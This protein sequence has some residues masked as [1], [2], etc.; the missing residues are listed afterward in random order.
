MVDNR[1]THPLRE[2]IDQEKERLCLDFI[3][4]PG[5]LD[6]RERYVMTSYYLAEI[7]MKK[8]GSNLNVSETTISNTH[9]KAI[10]KLEKRVELCYT[11][12]V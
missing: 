5:I 4:N 1:V 7:R 2:I 3:S 11:N 10:K 6:E 8:I 12:A 9:S